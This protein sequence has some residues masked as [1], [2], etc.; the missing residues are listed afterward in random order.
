[1]YLNNKSLTFAP[2]TGLR[3]GQRQSNSIVLQ[4]TYKQA[5]SSTAGHL[6]NSLWSWLVV[7]CLPLWRA[8]RERSIMDC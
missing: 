1:M 4:S 8:K 5:E 6:Y 3:E 7:G 2:D